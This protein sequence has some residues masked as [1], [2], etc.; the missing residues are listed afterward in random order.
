V[1]K[2]ALVE[3][4]RSYPQK[5][6]VGLLMFSSQIPGPRAPEHDQKIIFTAKTW[7]YLYGRGFEPEIILTS[8]LPDRHGLTGARYMGKQFE[9]FEELG[10]RLTRY[11]RIGEEESTY[12]SES[13]L[14]LKP[15]ILVGKDESP[16]Y[17]I[18][19]MISNSP[20]LLP[21]AAYAK[22]LIRKV[23]FVKLSS[24]DGHGVATGAE[25]NTSYPKYLGRELLHY[26]AAMSFDRNGKFLDR[27]GYGEKLRAL[28]RTREWPPISLPT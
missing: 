7:E 19:V 1:D 25:L 6:R 20:H 17:D 5:P 16:R 14:Q 18:I 13:L 23:R 3:L 28:C 24:G 22:H 9:L 21:S 15:H 4:L 26:L 12:T 10:L 27:L 8:G 2:T 11:L